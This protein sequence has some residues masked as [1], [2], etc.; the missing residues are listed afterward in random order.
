M[1]DYTY[2]PDV[3]IDENGR[4]VASRPLSKGEIVLI[5]WHMVE[6]LH[7]QGGVMDSTQS[8]K[9]EA[10]PCSVPPISEWVMCPD[11]NGSGVGVADT[12]CGRCDGVGGIPQ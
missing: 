1:T 7:R 3:E 4:I 11:C 10:A 5:P 8:G 9:I 2:S 12:V 6:Q